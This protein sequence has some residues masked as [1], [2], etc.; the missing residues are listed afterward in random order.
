LDLRQGEGDVGKGMLRNFVIYEDNEVAHIK[1]VDMDLA[2][3]TFERNKKCITNVR[4]VG[5]LVGGDTVTEC[6]LHK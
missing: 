4:N 5:N 1:E 6:M 2:R 3:R